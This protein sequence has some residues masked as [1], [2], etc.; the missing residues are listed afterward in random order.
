MNII[1]ELEFCPFNN[2]DLL[3]IYN[4]M[5][6]FFKSF[7]SYFYNNVPVD[8]IYKCMDINEIKYLLQLTLSIQNIDYDV[9]HYTKKGLL[10]I[11]QSDCSIYGKF[12]NKDNSIVVNGMGISIIPIA[13]HEISHFIDYNSGNNNYT[14]INY[15]SESLAYASEIFSALSLIKI[16]NKHKAELLNF[17]DYL[18]YQ[19]YVLTQKTLPLLLLVIKQKKSLEKTI[20]YIEINK[21]ISLIKKYFD[22]LEKETVNLSKLLSYMM[23]PSQMIYLLTEQR[24]FPFREYIRNASLEESLNYFEDMSFNYINEFKYFLKKMK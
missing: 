18:I 6:S 19:L 22:L 8:N 23:A 13:C 20:D 21:N 24:I 1:D 12:S 16:V 7:D 15:F 3:I 9:N 5:N 10:T 2:E 17:I 4:S 14:S 11:K